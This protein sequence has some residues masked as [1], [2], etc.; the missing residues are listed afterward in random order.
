A[1]NA[2]E[3]IKSIGGGAPTW[4]TCGTE[5]W[6]IV[7]GAVSPINDTLDL[8]IGSNATA[9]AKFAFTNVNDGDPTFIINDSATTESLS[10]SHDGISA[11][12][13]SSTGLINLGAAGGT[14]FLPMDIINN[15]SQFDGAV[16]ITDRLFIEHEEND[17]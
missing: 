16:K 4:G 6:R 8:L 13:V 12:I 5:S 7:A 10:L 1:G 11:N 15:T 14:L 9:S 17:L 3:C 2:G